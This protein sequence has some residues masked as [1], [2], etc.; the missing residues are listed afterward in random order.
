MV[1]MDNQGIEMERGQPPIVAIDGARIKKIR[2]EKRLT[3]LYVASVVGVTTDTISRWENN[4]YPTIRRDNAEK[5]AGAL[6]VELTEILLADKT[7]TALAE[8]PQLPA[9]IGQRRRYFLLTVGVAILAVALLLF[10]RQTITAPT[11]T[12]R[13]PHF[14]APTTTIPVQLKV[15]RKG[16]G[17]LGFIVRE[18]LP[19]GWRLISSVPE[20][21]AGQPAAEE[22]KW[23][24][25][26]GNG[27]VT[28]N[29]TVQLPPAIP[30][31]SVATFTG[32]IVVSTGE[33]TRSAPIGGDTGITV[34][35]YHWA[36]SNGDG[37]IDDSEVMPAYYLLEEMKGSG[38]DWKEIE[39]IWSSK[40]YR[41][42]PARK[43]FTVIK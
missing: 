38:L 42:D 28:I 16:A 32:N 39:T 17:D 18:R 19:A 9:N 1:T 3:Q 29:Y 15:S 20:A 40:G 24:I 11:A 22:A 14:A 30:L 21:T 13:L 7:D 35:G 34:A 6:E 2:E 31:Q 41:W 36:D 27:P 33:I 5:L 37:R 10:F 26:S 8:L 4:R 23:L 25:A 43:G 12:R